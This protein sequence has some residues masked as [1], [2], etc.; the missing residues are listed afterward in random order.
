VVAGSGLASCAAPG[1]VLLRSAAVGNRGRHLRLLVAQ[2]TVFVLQ[3]VPGERSA[4]PVAAATGLPGRV[5]GREDHS[6]TGAGPAAS[7]SRSR[8]WPARSAF[9]NAAVRGS[10]RWSPLSTP[11]CRSRESTAIG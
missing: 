7:V 1:I 10:S 6:A 5:T 11:A 2:G 8:S 9:M 4:P 3:G